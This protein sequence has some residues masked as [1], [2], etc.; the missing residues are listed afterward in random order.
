[1]STTSRSRPVMCTPSTFPTRRSTWC[2]RTRFSNTFPIRSVH[3]ARRGAC[4]SPTAWSRHATATTRPSPGIRGHPR[5]TRGCRSTTTSRGRTAVN[6]MRDTY[7]R[8]GERGGLLE[9]RTERVGLVLRHP[10]GS[11]VVGRPLGR[12][13]HD[14]GHRDA[15]RTGGLRDPRRPRIHGWRVAHLGCRSRRVVCRAARRDH[16]PPVAGTLPNPVGTLL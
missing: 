15:G 13:D 12:S 1:M 10:R 11:R 14:L 5:S 7:S 16:L 3:C 6:P 8:V 4:A 2:T 9:G